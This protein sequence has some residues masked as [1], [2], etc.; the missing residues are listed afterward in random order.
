MKNTPGAMVCFNI[1]HQQHEEL[2]ARHRSEIELCTAP[3]VEKPEATACCEKSRKAAF[4]DGAT[5]SNVANE[6][7]AK[8]YYIVL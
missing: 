3:N 2:T 6:C 5:I 7:I 8:S 4:S 1:A